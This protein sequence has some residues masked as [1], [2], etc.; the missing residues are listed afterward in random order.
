MEGGWYW[1]TPDNSKNS[2]TKRYNHPDSQ[3]GDENTLSLGISCHWLVAYTLGVQYP[4]AFNISP[5]SLQYYGRKPKLRDM[6][7]I[8]PLP[9]ILVIDKSH[10][11]LFGSLVTTPVLVTFVMYSIKFHQMVQYWRNLAHIPP[12]NID[13]GTRA[14]HLDSE[15]YI[16]NK[17]RSSKGQ[18]KPKVYV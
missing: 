5:I 1:A 14:R 8:C 18:S 10:K 3:L 13:I 2:N 12:L 9:I 11:Y 17:Y 4:M 6:K 7:Y 16:N 15:A